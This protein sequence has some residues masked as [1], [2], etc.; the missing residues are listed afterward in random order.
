MIALK[1]A[2]FAAGLLAAAAFL[3]VSGMWAGEAQAVETGGQ[4]AI[5]A[6]ALGAVAWVI[7]KVREAIQR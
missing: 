7:A 3:V 2:R 4:V 6:M 5:A 1:L